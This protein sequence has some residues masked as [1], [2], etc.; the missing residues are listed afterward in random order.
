[1]S[2]KRDEATAKPRLGIFG[3]GSLG[4]RLATLASAAG[5]DVFVGKRDNAV[6]V[7]D[8]SQIFIIAIPFLACA[9]ALPPI[10][11]ALTGKIVVDATNPLNS[12]WSPVLFGDQSSGGEEVAKLLPDSK[13]V[14]AFNTVF[15]DTMTKQGLLRDG[16][17]VTTFVCGDDAAAKT[18]VC[19]LAS[20]LG[21]APLESGPLR[22][23][24]YTEAIAHLNVY[25]AVVQ[26]GGTDAAF[27]YHRTKKA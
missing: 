4:G 26:G 13:V 23:C 7:A 20:S 17:Q 18:T 15:A 27:V 10:A 3:A 9:S 2:D 6:S 12:D 8:H 14:K 1:M 25:L 5:Y 19:D 24:R 21:F 11:A 16:Q 22:N